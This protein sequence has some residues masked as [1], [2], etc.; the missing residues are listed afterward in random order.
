MGAAMLLL[1]RATDSPRYCQHAPLPIYWWAD[2]AIDHVDFTVRE[3]PK[4]SWQWI[5]QPYLQFMELVYGYLETGDP[6][7]LQTARFAAD[8]YYRF[9][10]T[11]RPHRSVGRDTLPCY[12]LLALYACTGEEVYF[13]RMREILAEARRSYEQP[14]YYYPGHQSGAGPAGAGRAPSYGYIPMV[15]AAAHAMML[16]AADGRLPP[17]EEAA[18][19]RFMRFANNL[20]HDKGR[21]DHW[22][23]RAICQCYQPLIALA[24][25]YP[26][27]AG[28]W[29]RLLNFW[30]RAQGMPETHDGGKAFDWVAGAIRFDAWAWGAVW[31]EGALHLRPE[32]RLLD[33]PRAPK[34]A[35]IYTPMGAV[36][37]VY[38]GGKVRVKGEV[39]FKVHVTPKG[40]KR[41]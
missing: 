26:A 2:L 12:G 13:Q 10:C 20:S 6:Y 4:F 21:D 34:E 24:D 3:I 32:P 25:R 23:L 22:V 5:V 14:Q 29:L 19:W 15:H 18:A 37:V 30:N 41:P 35:T 9:F 36:E 40:R 31:K 33:Q 11:N 8:A 1:G 17:E 38:A 28:K 39:P 7:L 27:E 16:E